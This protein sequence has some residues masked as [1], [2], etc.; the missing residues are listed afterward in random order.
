MESLKQDLYQ[1]LAINS[2]QTIEDIEKL[3]DRDNWMK[4]QEAISMGFLD[5]IIAKK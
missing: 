4:P 2:G 3:C 5:Q 1:V